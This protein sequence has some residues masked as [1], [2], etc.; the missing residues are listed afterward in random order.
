MKMGA[1]IED[2]PVELLTSIFYRV[3][4]SSHSALISCIGSC[5]QWKDL[6]EPILW[7]NIFLRFH[8]SQRFAAQV[9]VLKHSEQGRRKLSTVRCLRI[10]VPGNG[11]AYAGGV[12]DFSSDKEGETI[13]AA[14]LQNAAQIIAIGVADLVGAVPYLSSL[15]TFHL[16][17]YNA[18]KMNG[19]EC[20][21]GFIPI[22]RS[23]KGPSP[24]IFATLIDALPPSVHNL[25]LDLSDAIRT[26]AYSQCLICPA[27][28]RVLPRLEHLALYL[29]TCCDHILL[30]MNLNGSGSSRLK[31]VI[32]RL[33]GFRSKACHPPVQYPMRR[34]RLFDV[35]KYSLL[36]Q[37]ARQ[38]GAFP[39]LASFLIITKRRKS[40]ANGQDRTCKWTVYVKDLYCNQTVVF[41]RMFLEKPNYLSLEATRTNS[42]RACIRIPTSCSF[43]PTERLGKEYVGGSGA[44]RR[45]VSLVYDFI[46]CAFTKSFR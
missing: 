24:D 45:L 26:D 6:A 8:N 16:M 33:Q 22:L 18:Q 27:V 11:R 7:R 12:H 35:N 36:I 43:I 10:A 46:F 28:N 39:E 34:T 40:G 25:C 30:P 29:R 14:P 3:H 31:S 32:M 37:N 1:S 41:P 13:V 20:F 17:V 9:G 21:L 4:A 38:N 2:L 19:P 42:P 23:I 15:K 5:R 44:I